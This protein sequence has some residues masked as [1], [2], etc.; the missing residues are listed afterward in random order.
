[1]YNEDEDDVPL[2][3]LITFQRAA[4]AANLAAL[5]DEEACAAAGV[6]LPVTSVEPTD[7][8]GI[9]LDSTYTD[10]DTTRCKH[11]FCRGCLQKLYDHL[12]PGERRPN[13]PL[14]RHELPARLRGTDLTNCPSVLFEACGREII[15]SYLL[16]R[17]NLPNHVEANDP[18][19]L[20]VR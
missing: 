15:A 10:P 11:T 7:P 4:E 17:A 19:A 18:L 5:V 13:C 16:G 6:P 1:M 2:D 8:C 9:C 14:C 3:D 20:Q 12:E